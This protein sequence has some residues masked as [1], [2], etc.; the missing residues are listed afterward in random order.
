MLRRLSA[1]LAVALMTLLLPSPVFAWS[2]AGH[3]FIMRR[4]I[5]LLPPEIKPFF[6]ER[7]E[8][9]VYRAI[10]PDLWR[11]AGFDEDPNHFVNFGV[12]EYGPYPF[13]A[14]PRDYTAAVEKFGVIALKRNGTLLW[15]ASEM[16]GNLRRAFEGFTKGNGLAPQQVVLFSA[17]ASHYI[18]DA[19]Q[20]FHTTAN[21]DGQL[22][23][24]RGVHGRFEEQ[25]LDR[26][27]AQLTLTPVAPKAIPNVRDY[28]FDQALASLRDVEAILKADKDAIGAKDTYDDE[29]FEALFAKTRPILEERLSTAITATASLIITAWEEAGRPALTLPARRAPAKVQRAPR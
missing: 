17:A 11:D 10:D 19:T 1:A 22:T 12:A 26:Y 7:R 21:Y 15:R 25:L 4:A 5:D 27:S 20:P 18:Q 2:W 8:E 29:Y 6:V 16:T 24:Q 28:T 23:D 9:I 14:L 13:V 3:R